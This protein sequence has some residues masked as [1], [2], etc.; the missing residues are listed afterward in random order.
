VTSSSA[1]DLERRFLRLTAVN[2]LSNLSVPLA[3]LVDTAMLG[4]LDEIRFLAGVALGSILFD[5]VYWTFGFLRMGT[6]GLTAQAVG[7]GDRQATFGVLYRFGLLAVSL[8]AAIVLLQLPLREGGF[9]VLAGTAEVESAGRAYFDARI[10]GAPATLANFVLLGWFLG[11]EEPR[12]ALWMTLAANLTNIALNYLFIVR[13]GWAARGAG[14]ATMLGQYAALGAG[15]AMLLR[16]PRRAPWRLGRVLR[17]EAWGSLFRLNRDLILRTLCLISAFAV[18]TNLSSV[19]GTVLLAANAILLRVLNMTAYVIDGGAFATETLAGR[20][21]G[22]RDRR[23][24]RRLHALSLGFGLAFA[25]CA[26]ALLFSAPRA[27][28]GLLTSHGDVVETALRFGPWLVPTLVLGSLAYMYDGMF[29]GL[30]DGRTLRNAMLLSFVG[31]FV[32]LAGAAWLLRDNHWLWG[33]LAAFM[34]A[35]AVTLAWPAR[36]MLRV[37][38]R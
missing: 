38:G 29:L 2:V 30:T 20:M 5:Y 37:D 16:V 21:L 23:G 9:A 24:L 28:Y 26:L 13:L 15:V 32:P 14:L 19:L 8:G 11:R 22:A 3:G 17:G 12:R 7:R 10:W 34:A 18:F 35:R 25:A 33:A 27:F 1:S 36:R 31:V 4:H 6:T